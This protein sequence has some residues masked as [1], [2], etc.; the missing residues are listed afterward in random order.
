MSESRHK[1][2]EVKLEDQVTSL[3]LS[4]QLKK[5]GVKQESE[6][7]WCERDYVSDYEVMPIFSCLI[8]KKELEKQED[9]LKGVEHESFSKFS[10]FTTATLDK[11]LP[12][13]KAN[14]KSKKPDARAKMIIHLIEKGL[15]KP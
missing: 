11:M 2:G 9:K 8:S 1:E 15:L 14:E 12:P 13:Y 6:F 3:E 10:A 7:Y 5:L 4:K